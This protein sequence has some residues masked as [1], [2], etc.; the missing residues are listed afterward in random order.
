MAEPY[1]LRILHLS[2]LHA[3]AALGWM[4]QERQRLIR[5][6]KPTRERVLGEAL[7]RALDEVRA[8]APV[9][10]V[11]FTGDIADWGLAP[12]YQLAGQVMSR[13]LQRLQLGGDRLFV[14]PGNHDVARTV[15]VEAWSGLRSLLATREDVARGLGRW[16]VGAGA[17][18]AVDAALLG[19]VLQRQ[20]AFWDWVAGGLQRPAL[21]PGQDTERNHPTLGYHATLRLDH[22]PFPVHVAGLNS[23]W[24]CGDD[25]DKGKS[26]VTREQV[27]WLLHGDGR[28]LDGFRLALMH[29]AL[30]DLPDWDA[31]EV[32]RTLGSTAD[33]L[34][35]GHQHDP[36]I[37]ARR[38][39]DRSLTI[40]ASGSL[41]EGDQ[42]DRFVNAWHVVDAFL[43]A[44]GR[45]QRL[46]LTSYGWSRNGHW[47][48]T[49]AISRRSVDGKLVWALAGTPAGGQAAAPPA[50]GA[51]PRLAWHPPWDLEQRGPLTPCRFRINRHFR[52]DGES[53][54]RKFGDVLVTLEDPPTAD[55]IYLIPSRHAPKRFHEPRQLLRLANREPK[56]RVIEE[57]VRRIGDT[58]LDGWLFSKT[59]GAD[60]SRRV[61]VYAK[62]FD[63]ALSANADRVARRSV[64]ISYKSGDGAWRLQLRELLDADKRLAVWDDSLLRPG[65]DYLDQMRKALGAARVM[66]VLASPEYLV[67]P[68]PVRH[69]LEPAI[70]LADAGEL[71]LLWVPIRR[72]DH[73]TSPLGRFMAPV[74][75]DLAL[76]DVDDGAREGALRALYEAICAALG[77][78]P[79]PKKAPSLLK[80]LRRVAS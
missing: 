75:P 54:W 40:V 41:Y 74:A 28:P 8:D 9:D 15:E 60:G 35:H 80:A 59:M 19:R 17:P 3:R 68:M 45:P 14:V 21:V 63:D 24:L 12:E 25:D 42:G 6:Q 18:A 4:S 79:K 78:K 10:L 37:E 52:S 20:S 48:R 51:P 39:P 70:A 44:G 26:F 58:T 55:D 47:H 67:S 46:E 23:A 50:S 76:A 43:D 7:D 5:V 56:Q 32:R 1:R 29:H 64:Y 73:T 49:S 13:I 72:F 69:E 62:E 36:D 27:D 30:G 22:L 77:L 16:A 53:R 38:D 34:L 61:H 2:D 71:T 31:A 57:L 66:V 65:P 11:C 33:L